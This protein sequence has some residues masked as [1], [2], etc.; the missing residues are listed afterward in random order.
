MQLN[1]SFD[2]QIVSIKEIILLPQVHGEGD[3]AVLLELPYASLRYV[4][5][6]PKPNSILSLQARIEAAILDTF[7]PSVLLAFLS[8]VGSFAPV[9]KS[10]LDSAF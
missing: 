8:L 7:H 1:K 4:A 3:P 2:L 5:V 10:I 9:I 6:A